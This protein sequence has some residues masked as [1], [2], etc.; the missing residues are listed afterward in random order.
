MEPTIN[1]ADL[2]AE[3]GSFYRA[4]S[5]NVKDVR[6]KL[7]QPSVT[8]LFF[9]SRLTTSTRLEL[10][11]SSITR[12]LQAYQ[13]AFTPIGDTTFKPQIITLDHLKIDAKIL[14][15]DLM[16]SWMGFLVENAQKPADTPLVKYW[17]E[18][19]VIPK[20]HE[21]L[22]TYEIFK[23]IKAPIVPGTAS[24]PGASMNGIK[25]K[26][27]AAGTNVITVGAVPTD[28]V[29]FC[30]YVEQ[31]V[32]EIP[33][34]IRTKIKRVAMN[35]NLELRFK[36]GKRAKYNQYYAQDTDLLKLA[37]F[38]CSVAGLPSHTGSDVIWTT[39]EDNKIIGNKNPKNQTTFDIQVENREVK[40]LTDFH[41]GVGFWTND[42]VYRNDVVL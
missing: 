29:E 13:S 8:E 7:M 30:E 24:A 19:L 35:P 32:A 37:D 3:F 36:Q 1:I 20:F 27:K 15:H 17:L 23:G 14:P 31:I 26:L 18:N 9:T 33:E 42:L 28:P 10:A 4:G 6:V 40:V 16:E 21:D 5:Q 38:D 12:V 41:K 22:E 2:L 34:L 25:E 39:I 11:N